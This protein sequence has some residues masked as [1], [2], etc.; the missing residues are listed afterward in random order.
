MKNALKIRDKD[1]NFVG[2]P[3]ISGADGKSAYQYAVDG[4]FRGTEEEF[5]MLLGSIQ[6]LRAD[7]ARLADALGVEL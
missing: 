3:A 2:I 7:V 4:G 5:A 6:Q 1:G